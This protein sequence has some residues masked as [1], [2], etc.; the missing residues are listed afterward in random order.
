MG[1]AVKG[2]TTHLD[3]PLLSLILG[4]AI[5]VAMASGVSGAREI[6]P[7]PR[8]FKIAFIADQGLTTGSKAVLQL[9]KDERVDMVL[10]QGDFDYIDDPYSWDEQINET[11]GPD[12]PYF[13]SIGNHDLLA[14][15][16]YQQKLQDR[17]DRIDG[18]VCDGELGVKSACVYQGIFFILS[19][20]GTLGSDHAD[21]IRDQLAASDAIWKICS[22]HK[23]QRLM[24]VGGKPDEVGWG[25]YDECRLGGAIIATGHEH[26]YERTYSLD[27]FAGQ[28]LAS[29]A[30]TLRIGPG[31]TFAFVSGRGVRLLEDTTTY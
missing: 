1:K 18:A 14:W 8:N 19:G 15:P 17:L 27:N 3:F 4:L 11:L 13:A 12:F 9:I 23:N 28:S 24:Q 25:P 5:T 6:S 10:H 30:E 2:L 20:A 22:W 31:R 21:F 7:T 29:R 26:S 16:G